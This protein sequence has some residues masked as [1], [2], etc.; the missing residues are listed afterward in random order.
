MTLIH[1]AIQGMTFRNERTQRLMF[2]DVTTSCG[3]TYGTT[4]TSLSAAASIPVSTETNDAPI[5]RRLFRASRSALARLAAAETNTDDPESP[6]PVLPEAVNAIH[7]LLDAVRGIPDFLDLREPW[8][9]TTPESGLDLE[10][11]DGRRQLNV[12]WTP[13]GWEMLRVDRTS[14]PPEYKDESH[15][16]KSIDGPFDGIRWFLGRAATQ[17]RFL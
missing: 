9:V 11:S 8:I 16:L 10:W 2:R 7:E 6:I 12:E 14:E 17:D 13:D 1:T 15:R 4:P 3:S 5:G